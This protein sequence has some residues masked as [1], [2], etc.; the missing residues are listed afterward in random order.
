M[1]CELYYNAH[2]GN[3]PKLYPQVL[4]FL[5]AHTNDARTMHEQS[6]Y[7][8]AFV[9][10]GGDGTFNTLLNSLPDPENHLF[11]LLPGGT[12]NSLY[13][14]LSPKE[15]AQDKLTRIFNAGQLPAPHCLDLPE[16][17][18]DGKTYRFINEASAGFAASIARE[19]EQRKTK[20]IFNR[21]HLSELAY[22]ATA[23]RCW[24]KDEPYFLSLCNNRRI[25][26]DLYPCVEADPTDGV[27]DIY[28][29]SCPRWRLPF[30]L[31]RLV[32]AKHDKPSAYVRRTQIS[33]A[34]F[35]IPDLPL[36]LDGNPLP[37]A[38]DITLSLYPKQIHVI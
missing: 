6:P 26:G 5:Q 23:F 20:Q 16:L 25:S 7:H 17:T 1:I 9:V 38:R 4:A 30:E 28:E 21:L 19:I 10:L 15:N 14:Q 12:S 11:I 32:K 33:N 22:I 34:G 24:L 29:L 13:S 27:I 37:P 18:V 36:E 3:A 35:R 2:A 31:T 8:K